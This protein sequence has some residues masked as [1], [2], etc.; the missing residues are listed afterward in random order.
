M[1]RN[2]ISVE[3]LYSMINKDEELAIIDTRAHLQD[4]VKGKAYYHA[5]HIPGAVHFDLENDL[6]GEKETHGG[7]HPLPDVDEFVDLLE[8]AG[9]SNEHPVIVYDHENDMFASRAWWMIQALGH[10]EVYVLDGGFLAWVGEGMPVSRENATPKRGT[11]TANDTFEGTATMEEVKNR[12]KKETVL[13]DSRAYERYLGNVEP[14]YDRAGH[15]P[16]AESYFWQKVLTDD[17]TWK[18]EAALQANF[19]SINKDKEI[20]VSCGSGVSACPNVQAL[21]TLGYDNVKLYVGSYS[22]WISYPENELETED[23]TK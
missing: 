7:A 5:G 12:N 18:D 10:K 16:G 17:G 15:I 14:L 9:V 4:K 21:K 6:S 13:I 23:E 1:M 8:R 11:F 3:Q 20:I 2:I 19:E 22:D